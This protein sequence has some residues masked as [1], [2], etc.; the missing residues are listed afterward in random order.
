[1]QVHNEREAPDHRVSMR[2]RAIMLFLALLGAIVILRPAIAFQSYSRA[3]FFLD[4]GSIG[5]AI[6]QYQR[7]VLLDP[8][9]SDAYSYL[10][11]ALKQDKQTEKA[12]EAYNKALEINRNDK[13]VFF[14]LGHIYL[15]Q[16][17]F[18]KAAASFEKAA[19][20]DTSDPN[21]KN[22]YA[23]ALNK[24]GQTDRAI[25]VWEDILKKDPQYKPAQVSLDK[26]KN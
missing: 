21:T 15:S 18:K 2:D 17:D 1:M 25:A 20:L 5:K 6:S 14:E 19:Q 26:Y 10:G 3:N 4:N 23:V 16:K 9:F 22:M 7:A 13:Q 8:S 11:F 24:D 12:I